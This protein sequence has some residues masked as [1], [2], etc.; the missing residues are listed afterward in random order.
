MQHHAHT[1]QGA[2]HLW[3]LSEA[4]DEQ[5]IANCCLWQTFSKV[6][7]LEHLLYRGTM[8]STMENVCPEQFLPHGQT[9]HAG[10]PLHLLQI[11]KSQCPSIFT[12]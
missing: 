5:H 10:H 9:C 11:L 1:Q 2:D 8:E 7:A 3:R 12:T 6:S 4:I